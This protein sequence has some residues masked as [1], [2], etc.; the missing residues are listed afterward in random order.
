MAATSRKSHI[1]MAPL[2]RALRHAPP[3]FLHERIPHHRRHPRIPHHRRHPRT[4]P[5]QCTSP[6]AVPS[7]IHIQKFYRKSHTET[8]DLLC[9]T[10]TDRKSTRLNSSH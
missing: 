10:L 9:V 1:E 8:I 7:A 6:H 5:F 4:A 3:N 2:L